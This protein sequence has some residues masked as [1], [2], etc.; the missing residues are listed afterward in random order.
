MPSLNRVLLIGHLGRDA[1]LKYTPN[2]AEVVTLSLATT[3]AWKDKDG[4][5]KE[6]TEWHRIVAWG[7]VASAIA[8]HLSKGSLTYVEGVIESRKWQDKDGAEKV[9]YE[10]K[11]TRVL[12]LSGRPKAEEAGVTHQSAQEGV[13]F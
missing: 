11:A 10:I 4:Q 8:P 13:P 9:A 7:K 3:D 6:K 12:L 2:G 5:K 1:E